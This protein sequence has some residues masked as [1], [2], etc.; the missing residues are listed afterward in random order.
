MGYKD[1][2]P[3]PFKPFY[4]KVPDFS[5]EGI[6]KPLDTWVAKYEAD[7]RDHENEAVEI[8][9]AFDNQTSE[10]EATGGSMEVD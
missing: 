5:T 9:T 4:Q 3:W 10:S 1:T 6:A 7:T 8:S 2:P